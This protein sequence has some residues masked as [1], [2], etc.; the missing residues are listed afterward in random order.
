MEVVR[1]GKKAKDF[2]FSSPTLKVKFTQKRSTVANS[3]VKTIS[4][5]KGDVAK[6]ITGPAPK[7]PVGYKKK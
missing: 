2:T 5:A 3:I 1:D 6:K 7:C 4:W